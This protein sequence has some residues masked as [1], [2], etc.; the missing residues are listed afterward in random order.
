MTATIP[1]LTD[2][3]VVSALGNM[4]SQVKDTIT[5][6]SESE[7]H[8]IFRSH[9][10]HA[11]K[12]PPSSSSAQQQAQRHH[13]RK[14]KVPGIEVGKST[15]VIYIMDR[16][17]ANGY[18][19]GNQEW[20]NFGQGAPEVGHIPGASDK[21]KTIDLDSMGES[22]HEYAP[23]AGTKKL[24]QAVAD[25][26]NREFDRK[27]GSKKKPYGVQ[28]VCIVPGGRTGLSRVAAVLGQ[29]NLGYSIPVY[30]AYE[31]MLSSFSG[32]VPI[33]NQTDEAH[34]YKLKPEQI[35]KEIRDRGLSVFLLSNPNNPTGNQMRD[36]ELAELVRI[37]RE[38]SCS[39][40]LDEFYSWYQFQ[41]PEGKAVSAAEYVEDPD[42]DPIILID[43]LTKNWRCPGWRVCWVVGPTEVISAVS[44]AGSFLDGGACHPMQ[45]M[46]VQ[47]L[48]ADRVKQDRVALQRH[49]KK[50]RDHVLARLAKM[51]LEVKVPPEASFYLWVDLKH[52]P[53]PINS[54]LVFAEEALKEK[55]CVTPGIF[56]DI[57]PKHRRNI[58]DSPCETFIRL[59]FGPPLEEL[60]RGLDGFER[61]I[62]KAKKGDD[63]LG[64]DYKPSLGHASNLHSAPAAGS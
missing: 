28:N 46:A 45:E 37:G 50:K 63:A 55:V 36:E 13:E 60:D 1:S 30:S 64:K 62:A 10:G 22:V 54:G 6:E 4:A 9:H 34:H 3:P 29:V 42:E 61:L 40:I 11:T 19:V 51:D 35:R 41:G 52:L 33:P 2:N 16:A 21:P 48:D 39:M 15:G 31:Q 5:H 25:Y 47:M 43:G 7:A 23:T 20:S 18:F 26:Y 12:D 27:E 44:A 32:F 8:Q 38:S 53:S 17:Q 59:S 24:R 56:F 14:H 49:F 57:N 58:L